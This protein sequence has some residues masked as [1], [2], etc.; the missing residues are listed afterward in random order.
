M[1]E[2]VVH[3]WVGKDPKVYDPFTQVLC[4]VSTKTQA[5]WNPDRDTVVWGRFT[6][7]VNCKEC[8]EMMHA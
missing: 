8:L 4:V 7:K 5:F 1:S 2:N 3:L 6:W